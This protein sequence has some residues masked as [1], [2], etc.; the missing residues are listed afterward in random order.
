[1]GAANAVLENE[2]KIQKIQL[3][4]MD[5][6]LF[7]YS[8]LIRLDEKTSKPFVLTKHKKFSFGTPQTHF[9]YNYRIKYKSLLVY[10]L[11]FLDVS[12]WFISIFMNIEVATFDHLGIYLGVKK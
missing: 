12:I 9:Y 11:F 4:F 1:M 10:F 3:K 5:I 2:D 7:Y 6:D 8:K